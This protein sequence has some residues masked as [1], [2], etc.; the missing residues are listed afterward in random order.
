[1]RGMHKNVHHKARGCLQVMK[2]NGCSEHGLH[3]KVL[4]PGQ[5]VAIPQKWCILH[6][7]SNNGQWLKVV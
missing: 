7:K 3:S 2:F 1:M 4:V 6:V 5:E